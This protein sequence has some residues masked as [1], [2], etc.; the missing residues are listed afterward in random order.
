MKLRTVRELGGE[1]W[2]EIT[3]IQN[4]GASSLIARTDS[5]T[6]NELIDLVMG[7]LARR[8]EFTIVNDADLPVEPLPQTHRDE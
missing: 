7:V 6:T 4:S 5:D 3:R 2:E 8:V 1:I